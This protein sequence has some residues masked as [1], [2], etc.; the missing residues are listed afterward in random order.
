MKSDPCAF[1]GF[2]SSG[3]INLIV[4]AYV[5]DLVIAGEDHAVRKFIQDIQEI[6]S[7]KHVEYLTTDHP[8]EFLG[9]IIKVKKSRCMSGM[10]THR[11][12]LIVQCVLRNKDVWYAMHTPT[13]RPCTL[14]T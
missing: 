1:T 9:R 5:D 14:C 11:R 6:F 2:H 3:H 8:V 7:L 12:F 4:M 10:D 13:I